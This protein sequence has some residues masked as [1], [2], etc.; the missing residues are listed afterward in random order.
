MGNETV[1]NPPEATNEIDITEIVENINQ[2]TE[3]TETHGTTLASHAERLASIE[4][5]IDALAEHFK[6]QRAGG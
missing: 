2:L 3:K 4:E 5:S 6:A 1:N